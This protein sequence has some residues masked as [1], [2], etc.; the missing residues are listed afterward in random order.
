[1]VI[2]C[3]PPPLCRETVKALTVTVIRADDL[4][5]PAGR[6]TCD[7]LVAVSVGSQREATTAKRKTVRPAWRESFKFTGLWGGCDG[8]GL[9][10]KRIFFCDFRFFVKPLRY[11]DSDL[12]LPFAIFATNPTDMILVGVLYAQSF[13]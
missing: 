5:V 6:E 8:C 1:M 2:L 13:N 4:V 9:D 10:A 12:R 11:E 3:D 7:P